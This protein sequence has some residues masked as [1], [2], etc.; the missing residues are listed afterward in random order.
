MID[1]GLIA[2][3]AIMLTIPAVFVTP[4]PAD[5]AGSG[6]LDVSLGAGFFGLAIGRLAAV[7]I[8]DPNSLTNLTDLLIIRSGV[9]FWPGALAGVAWLA[10]AARKADVS[11]ARRIASLAPAGLIAWA[12][13]E[14]TCLLRDGCPGPLSSLGLRPKGL[15]S[16]VFPVGLA[17]AFAAGIAAACIHRLH[18]RGMPAAEVIVATV[19]AV[20]IIR[21]IASIWLPKVGHGLTRQHRESIAVA[22]AAST[23]M[24]VLQ[25][26]QHKT[27]GTSTV[28]PAP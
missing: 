18:R 1:I 20:A 3:I 16:S 17:V 15:T 23:T 12:C 21:S 24:L 13:F 8:D 7:A 10:F 9:E 25:V 11:A 26:R 27:A 19:G 4:W 28:A 2:T 14:A 22:L 6:L 5:A